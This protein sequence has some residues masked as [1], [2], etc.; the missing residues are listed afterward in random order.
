[1]SRKVLLIT[2]TFAPYAFP[3]SYLSA[4]RMGNIPGI[5][6][7]VLTIEPFMSDVRVDKKFGLYAE[8]RFNNVTRLKPPAW[9]KHLPFARLQF[10]FSLPDAYL[11]LNPIYSKQLKEASKYDAIFTWSMHHSAHLLG[12]Y[13]KKR[14]PAIRWFAHFSDPW[15]KNPFF[16]QNW[17]TKIINKYLERKVFEQADS[18]LFTSKETVDLVLEAYPE[19]IREKAC[20]VPHAFDESLYPTTQKTNRNDIIIRYIGNFYGLRQP[21]G[22]IKALEILF[23][24]H[25]EVIKNIKLDFIG[26]SI[27]KDSYSIPEQ[28]NS[29]INFQEPVDYL[30]SLKLMKEADLLLVIDAPFENS[31]FL[32]SKLIDYIGAGR[33]IFGIT[34]PGTS[35]RVL[36]GLGFLTANPNN[37]QEIANSLLK[38]IEGVQKGQYSLTPQQQKQFSIETVGAQMAELLSQ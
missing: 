2:H 6:V 23:A 7:D 18:L 17:F 20:I 14:N 27:N 24:N 35:E 28:L 3:E 8:K 32:P 26:S 16:M 21:T 34:P 4:K 25:F 22:L 33:P 5:E 15:V 30:A 1:V 19:N 37:P 38:M 29:Y 11:Y 31:P 13:V 10:L 12:R 36:K 9:Y